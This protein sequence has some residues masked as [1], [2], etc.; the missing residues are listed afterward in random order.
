[1]FI[2]LKRK[3]LTMNLLTLIVGPP[4]AGKTTSFRDLGS[5]TLLYNTEKKMLPFRNNGIKLS[6]VNN[7]AE[8]VKKLSMFVGENKY[9]EIRNII[10]DSFSDYADL[11]FAEC[12]AKYKGF[13]VYNAYNTA[14]YEFFQLLK[15]IENKYIFLTGHPETLADADGNI[16]FRMFV[17]G[18]EWEGKM[19]KVATCVFY[20]DPKRKADGKGVEYRFMTN[21]DG[22]YPAKTPMG[23]FESQH[24]DNNIKSVVS[25]YDEFYGVNQELVQLK[26]QAA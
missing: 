21:T 16:I 14:V 2:A 9:P 22:R 19:E 7:T 10:I 18:K 1:V 23:M 12:K 3:Q 20:C 26:E 13:E 24:I 6:T 15:Q 11:L 17:R 5:E 4:G 25:V 8:L